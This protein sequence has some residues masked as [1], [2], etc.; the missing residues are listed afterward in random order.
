MSDMQ[1]AVIYTRVSTDDQARNGLSLQGQLQSARDYCFSNNIDVLE[2]FTDAGA[3]AKTV[4]RPMLTSSLEYCIAN[5]KDID[6]YIVWKMDR[7]ARN[8]LDSATIDATLTKLGIE[9]ISVTEPFAQSSTGNLMKT[10]LSAFAQFDNDVRS[11]RSSAG[12]KRRIE[13]GGWPY[14]APLGYQNHKDTLRRPTLRKTDM[15]PIIGEWLREYIRTEGS[16]VEMNQL[17]WDAGIR[18]RNGKRLGLQQ[19]INMLR[20]PVYA[21]LV[22]SRMITKPIKGLHEGVISPK[23]HAEI[24]NLLDKKKKQP[25]LTL[26]QDEWPL[27][28]GFLRCSECR[29]GLTGSSPRGRTKTYPMYHCPVCRVKKVGHKVSV[30]KELLHEQ[31]EELLETITPHE[32]TMKLFK[33]V[34]VKKWQSTHQQ[35]RDYQKQKQHD[36]EKLRDR[37]QR[38]VTLF[39]DGE[40]SAEEKNEQIK[41]IDG[42]IFRTELDLNEVNSEIIDTDALINFGVNM[43]QN[44]KKLWKM[45]DITEKQQLQNVIFPNGIVYDFVEGLGT[46]ETSKLYEVIVKVDVNE[47]SLVGLDGIEPST[48]WL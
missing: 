39:I 19:T 4:D 26:G 45:G 40:L 44:A 34:V 36:L 13:E 25:K 46:P 18:S 30:K 7:L 10:M 2:V 27:R 24:L 9:L 22:Y 23:D 11:E 8:A 37:K 32:A 33:Q 15:A 12:A 14:L 20:N 31:F 6:Y 16:M 5:G 41:E 21:G 35:Q 3:S 1:K 17:A 43:I 48:K 29:S 38:V 42:D 28:G 47:S